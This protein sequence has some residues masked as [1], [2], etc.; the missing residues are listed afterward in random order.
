MDSQSYDL[1]EISR[2]L[3]QE[4]EMISVN[5]NSWPV[6]FPYMPEV[7]L[8]M[9]YNRSDIFLKFLVKES[10]IRAKTESNNGP[11]YQDSCV[12]F[13]VRPE[14]SAHYYNYEFNCIGTCLMQVGTSRHNRSFAPDQIINKIQR[15]SS[16]GHSVIDEKSGDYQWDLLV[17]I[18]LE[19]MYI[20]SLSSF[21]NQ[22]MTGNFYKCGDLLSRP[23][24]LS[25]NPV[26]TKEPDFHQPDFFGTIHFV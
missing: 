21:Q 10:N 24:Y 12:E 7:H 4:A 17:I 26:L 2:I 23:H 1:I 20:D 22:T 13:F 11:V 14:G 6:E 15:R 25:W 16:L 9:A 8:R 18:P 5:K 3:N 19:T